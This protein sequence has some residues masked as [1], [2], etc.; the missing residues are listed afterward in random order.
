MSSVIHLDN[1]TITDNYS[2]GDGGGLFS[3]WAGATY[4]KD[5]RIYNNY[6]STRGNDLKLEGSAWIYNETGNETD[7]RAVENLGMDDYNAW[8]DD[9]KIIQLRVSSS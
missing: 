6:A 8:Y 7:H 9:V 1:V 4:F 3:N 5:T 2:T